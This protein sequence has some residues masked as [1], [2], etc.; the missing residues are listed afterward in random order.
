M[1]LEDH[2]NIFTGER[3]FECG[4]CHKRFRQKAHLQKHETTHS[5][6]TPYQCPHCDKAFGHPSNLN[7]H[8]ATHSDVRY[9]QPIT[10]QNYLVLTNQKLIFSCFRPYECGDC[11]KSYKDSASF[12][13]HR[14]VH[15]GERPYNCNICSDT[16]IDS[17][18]LRRHRELTH[19][20]AVPDPELELE[21]DAALRSHVMEEE[22]EEEIEP[23]QEQQYHLPAD[24]HQDNEQE[25]RESVDE[26]LPADESKHID[27]DDDIESNEGDLKIAEN[28]T[29]SGINES[30]DI[31]TEER[32]L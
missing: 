18:S 1:I 15:T 2:G 6:A 17:K 9:D 25:D 19:P 11:G 24:K 10:D 7:T 29:D 21:D 27:D 4:V 13:R 26:G 3:P 16:F 23:G 12:K 20:T 31:S 5:S 22:E 32:T 30:M 14:M 8:I 28:L